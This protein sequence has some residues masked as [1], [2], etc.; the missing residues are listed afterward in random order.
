M[1]DL[2]QKRWIFSTFFICTKSGVASINLNKRIPKLAEN[3]SCY[4]NVKLV[5]QA[6][7]TL[8]F[9]PFLFVPNWGVEPSI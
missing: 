4:S 6:V 9:P 1:V 7:Y 8:D 5:P 2:G 3:N